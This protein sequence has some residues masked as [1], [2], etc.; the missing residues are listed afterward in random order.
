MAPY[1][2]NGLHHSHLITVATAL[3]QHTP[4][5]TRSR[6]LTPHMSALT[7]PY[8]HGFAVHTHSCCTLTTH[9]FTYPQT[10]VVPLSP[11]QPLEKMEICLLFA[12]FPCYR[13]QE[14]CEGVLMGAN[15]TNPL[16]VWKWC[17]FPLCLR[18]VEKLNAVGKRGNRRCYS[19]YLAASNSARV[20]R[21]SE[22]LSKSH[23]VQASTRAH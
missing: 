10:P 6:T 1:S 19:F 15:D 17:D 22:I 16:Y 18:I 9:T 14:T 8:M 4:T 7:A 21:L 11:P 12:F 20:R 23:L 3:S 2:R 13:R 5:R